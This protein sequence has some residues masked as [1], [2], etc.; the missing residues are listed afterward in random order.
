MLVAWVASGAA[1]SGAGVDHGVEPG[2]G[3]GPIAARQTGTSGT[4]LGRGS[5]YYSTLRDREPEE[6]VV[7]AGLWALVGNGSETCCSILTESV[8]S[9]FVFIHDRQ[10]VVLDSDDRWQRLDPEPANWRAIRKV[11]RRL[12]RD[13]LTAYPVSTKVNRPASDDP[14]LIEEVEG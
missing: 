12:D 6:V 1:L 14:G 3:F 5:R 7:F 4:R 13:R 2:G 9:D 8:P 11:A 10:L